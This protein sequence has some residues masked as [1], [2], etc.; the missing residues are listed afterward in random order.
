MDDIYHRQELLEIL[1]NPTN[2]GVLSNPD[3]VVIEANPLCGDVVELA[4]AFSDG[5]ITDAKFDGSACAVS[6]ISSELVLEEIKG[7]TVEE[8]EQLTKDDVLKLIDA[9][10]TT[11]RVKCA[12]LVLDALQ[13]AVKKL[14]MAKNT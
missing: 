6:V 7:K 4:L 12:T 1:R 14:E 9:N 2:K 11:S 5:K 8:V 10:L 13:H 3:V